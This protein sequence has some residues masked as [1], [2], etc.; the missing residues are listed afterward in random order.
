MLLLDTKFFFNFGGN[1]PRHC[2]FVTRSAVCM[3]KMS[4]VPSPLP[5]LQTRHP[6]LTHFRTSVD[7]QI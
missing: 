6:P 5:D 1:I 4:D 3:H 7:A 2:S